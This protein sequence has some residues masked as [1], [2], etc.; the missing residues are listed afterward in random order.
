MIDFTK[1]EHGEEV[2][3]SQGISTICKK[4]N[5]E[6]IDDIVP[7]YS[8]TNIIGEVVINS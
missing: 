5:I 3:S 2:V 8:L 1:F 6:I 4:Y 7:F